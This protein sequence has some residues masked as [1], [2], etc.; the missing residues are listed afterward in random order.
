MVVGLAMNLRIHIALVSV[1]LAGCA[2]VCGAQAVPAVPAE[3]G[4]KD[5]AKAD[6]GAGY[7]RAAEYSAGLSGRAVLVLVHGEKVFE[8]YDNGWSA[9]RVHPLASGTKSFTGVAA[10]MAVQDGLITL[11]ELA[12][13]TLT[14]WRTDPLK[15]KITIRELLTLS[16]GLD[17]ADDL[18]GGRGGSRLLG[19][20]RGTKNE[21]QARKPGDE[22]RDL[23]A[24]SLTV[25]MSGTP[26]GQF[27]YGPSHFYAFGEVLRRKLAAAKDGPKTVFDYYQRRIFEPLGLTFRVGKDRA[28]NPKLPGGAV[29]TAGE[30]ATFGQFVLDRGSWKGKDGTPVGLLRPELLEECFKPSARNPAY[31]LTWWRLTDDQAAEGADVADGLLERLRKRALEEQTRGVTGPDG[32]PLNVCMAAGKGKQRLYVIPSLGMVV[33]RFAEDTRAGLAFSDAEFLS[34]LLGTK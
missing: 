30:W 29:L 27:R 25:K 9:G 2:G 20:G 13:E 11:D 16:S 10:M 15:S 5:G 6:A 14:E 22:P 4:T 32:K 33:V 19:P 34:R 18:L 31:G 8:R 23:F 28:G 3:P 12:C 26:G 1:V 17:P 21:P 24:E 7:S